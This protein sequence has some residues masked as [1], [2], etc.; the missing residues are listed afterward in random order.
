LAPN[1]SGTTQNQSTI[2]ALVRDAANNPVAD[3][4]VNFSISAG[5]GST[6]SSAAAKT[7]ADGKARI[8][9]IS[10]SNSSAANGITVTATTADLGS[11]TVNGSVNLTINNT[12]LFISIFRGVSM[13]SYDTQTY[14]VPF[15]LSVVDA[16][17]VAVANKAIDLSVW[18][19]NYG[20]GVLNWDATTSLWVR[21]LA[22]SCANEDSN[23]NGT[24][25][26]G[27]DTNA[28]TT[29]EPGLPINLPVSQVT[30]DAAGLGSFVIRYGKNNARWIYA[31]LTARGSVAGT[32]S[33]STYSDW[34]PVL[35]DDI[36]D[37]NIPP[38]GVQTS[39]TPV[40]VVS[41]FGTA[42][43]CSNPN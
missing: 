17:G 43:L 4:T 3:Y 41:P 23:R 5:A 36:S 27:E 25:D 1:A 40:N 29:L 38:P 6:L 35:I 16:N 34:L 19:V 30:T 22:V 28:N 31:A 33:S 9:F 20:K 15:T 13:S 12:A 26:S 39:T 18:P 10:G 32:E 37:Q 21:A 14:Q 24:L 8:Q 7:D 42:A 11:G 2:E